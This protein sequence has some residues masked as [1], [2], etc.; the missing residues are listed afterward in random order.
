VKRIQ[1]IA[2]KLGVSVGYLAGDEEFA[3][4]QREADILVGF[5]N[6]PPEVQAAIELLAASPPR[7]LPPPKPD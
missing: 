1:Q 4:N 6:K 3:R 7:L 5:R 2:K